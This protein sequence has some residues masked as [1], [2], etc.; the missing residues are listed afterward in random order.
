MGRLSR[1]AERALGCSAENERSPLLDR[2][3]DRRTPL[4]IEHRDLGPQPHPLASVP[5]GPFPPWLVEAASRREALE[6]YLRAFPEARGY[7]SFEHLGPTSGH[8]PAFRPHH[9]GWAVLNMHWRVP[10]EDEGT[11]AERLH[12]LEVLTRP[13]GGTWYFFPA[14]PPTTE[15]LHPLMAWWAVLHTLSMLARYQPAEWASHIDVDK[16]PYAV[17][18]ER[19]LKAAV[20]RIPLLVAET[21]DQVASPQSI[22]P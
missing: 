21:I 10:E 13:Y 3:K 5:V 1:P 16:S 2:G 8:A 14:M 11:R 6:S 18:I 20:K 19:L 4:W 15:S 17:G 22:V 9:D 12:L 7:D